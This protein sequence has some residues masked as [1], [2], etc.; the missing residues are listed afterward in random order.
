MKTALTIL[1]FLAATYS[2]RSEIMVGPSLEWLTDTSSA[3]GVFA[4][5]KSNHKTDSEFELIFRLHKSIKGSVPQVTASSYSVRLP[6]DT[7]PPTVD[8]GDR[9][10]MFFKV[11][12]K[13]SLQ[14]AHL[15]NLTKSQNGGMDSVAIT[16]KFKVLTEEA[17]ILKLV[18]QRFKAF[19]NTTTTKW[20]EYPNSRFDV[21]VPTD[22]PAYVFLYGGSACYL[23]VPDDLK[24]KK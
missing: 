10:L 3:V 5:T 11:D 8:N 20:R 14:V 4:V 23:L 6:K 17:E 24:T 15:I 1:L 7:K 12:E 2:V 9:F 13:A 19:P 22:S 21:E 16:S 18:E